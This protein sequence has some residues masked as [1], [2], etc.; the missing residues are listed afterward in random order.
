M[1]RVC[2]LKVQ[3]QMKIIS[4][5]ILI[6]SLQVHSSGVFFITSCKETSFKIGNMSF[7]FCSKMNVCKTSKSKLYKPTD[8]IDVEIVCSPQRFIENIYLI[9][10]S[11]DIEHSLKKQ[12]FKS[13][14]G[15]Y[16]I[17]QLT[18]YELPKVVYNGKQVLDSNETVY[19]VKIN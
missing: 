10:E 16:Y 18:I 19:R 12:N 15:E 14:V 11:K 9:G 13:N 3:K 17:E 5:L 7:G 8:K 1:N 4:L 6:S 2:L